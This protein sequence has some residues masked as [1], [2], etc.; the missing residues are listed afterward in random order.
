MIAGT[1]AV[2]DNRVNYLRKASGIQ[3]IQR[4]AVGVYYATLN[5]KKPPLNDVRVRQA[6]NYGVDKEK[7]IKLA[8]GGQG[9]PATS[10]VASAYGAYDPNVQKYPYDFAKAQS[11]LRAAGADK[12]F[13]VDYLNIEAPE[14]DLVA[15][16]VQEDLSKLGITM[17]I[18]SVPVA[19]WAAT[20]QTQKPAIGF[21]YYTYSDPDIITLLAQTG[22]PFEWTYHGDKTLD[23][24]LSAQRLAFDQAKRR[25]LLYKIQER[26]N[27]MAYYLY[28]W[29]GRYSAA[30]RDNVKNVHIDLVG[31]IHAQE[32]TLS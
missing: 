8:A 11:L 4:S 5:M 2:P 6:I 17:K 29:E 21:I 20:G 10:L 16:S 32:I 28:L 30:A 24:W 31:F 27:K 15:Q 14:F 12:G 19:Q 3:V 18:T 26:I 9:K 13:T 1:N 25:A 23:E 22:Q 7:L